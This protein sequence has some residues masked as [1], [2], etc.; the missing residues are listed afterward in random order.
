MLESNPDL[1][2]AHESS[3]ERYFPGEKRGSKVHP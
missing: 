2:S 1:A 3:N